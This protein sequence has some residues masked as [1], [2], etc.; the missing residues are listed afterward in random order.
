[1]AITFGTIGTGWITEAFIKAASKN[2][3]WQLQAVYSRKQEQADAFASKFDCKTTYT[4]LSDLA[5]DPN[6]Q[7]IYIASPN[8]SSRNPQPPPPKNSTTSLRP[9]SSTTSSL[10]K[11]SATSKKPTSNSSAP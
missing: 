2:N 6:L 11:P 4:S 1:M 8:S 5:A 3:L 9:P 7:A 10:S